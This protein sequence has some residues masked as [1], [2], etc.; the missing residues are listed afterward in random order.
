MKNILKMDF[1]WPGICARGFPLMVEENFQVRRISYNIGLL[2]PVRIYLRYFT[3][4]GLFN[5]YEH[6][7]VLHSLCE[8]PS[9]VFNRLAE[10]CL[11]LC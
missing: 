5:T 1:T 3:T 2:F 10:F 11:K 8:L 9:T 7:S 6:V 4:I